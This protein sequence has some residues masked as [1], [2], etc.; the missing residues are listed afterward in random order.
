MSRFRDLPIRRKLTLFIML[1]SS[2]AL[3]MAVIAVV[4]YEIFTLKQRAVSDLS[5]LGEMIGVSAAPALDFIDKS[6][7]QDTLDT[8]KAE[9][10]I[11]SACIY[12]TKGMVFA[13]YVRPGVT[14][15]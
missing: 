3:L 1:V 13:S 8:L 12:D 5:T 9:R 11:I 14:N 10:E 6:G 7:A 4:G 2:L 15:V